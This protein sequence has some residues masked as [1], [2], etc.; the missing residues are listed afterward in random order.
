MNGKSKAWALA[1]L[2]AVL[3]LGGV[4]GA[5][6][7]RMLVGERTASSGQRGRSGDRDRRRS[8][9]DWLS[10]Q[11]ELDEE[12]Q[13]QVQ[14]VVEEYREQIS[15]I[16]REVR[17]RYEELQEQL[18]A[19]IRAVLTEEQAA[20]YD[21]LLQRQRERHEREVDRRHGNGNREEQDRS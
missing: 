7:D 2:V 11:L 8:Y 3:L 20:N 4:A 14:V 18:R 6:V 21:A 10:A 15:S 19:E 12:Q 17:P 5:A 9:L 16:W 13:A 1:L